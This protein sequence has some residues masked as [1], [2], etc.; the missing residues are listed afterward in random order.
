MLT[1][2]A[3]GEGGAL[4]VEGPAGIGK[5]ALLREVRDRAAREGFVVLAAR[6]AELERGFSFGVVRQLFET[7][8]RS[9]PE[10]ERERILSGAAHLALPAIGELDLEGSAGPAPGSASPSLDASFAVLHGLYWLTSNIA[11]AGPLLIAVDDAHWSDVESLRFLD[12]LAGRLEGLAAMLTVCARRFE[13]GSFDQLL[14]ALDSEDAS[15]V[16][17]LAPLTEIATDELVRSR[18]TVAPGPGFSAACHEVTGGNPQLIRELLAALAAEGVEPTASGAELVVEL[19]AD[20]IAAS[21]L[22]RAGRAGAPAVSLARAVAVLGGNAT[23]ELAAA[24]AGLKPTEATDAVDAL[25]GAG[26]PLAERAARLRASNRSHGRLQRLRLRRAR[27]IACTRREVVERSR[28]R[29]R[30]RRR[31]ARRGAAGRRR[32]GGCA[33]ERGGSCGAVAWRAGRCGGIPGPGAH[34]RSA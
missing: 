4:V 31:P 23:I 14:A 27:S 24:L 26:D 18:L 16:L 29:P 32:M 2:A 20:R 33:A 19:R 8:V 15:R 5:S 25:I 28:R 1:A 30:C 22:A 9:A 13:P 3:A 12:Y 34:R 7:H 11:E 6:G 21:I 10:T 17:Q